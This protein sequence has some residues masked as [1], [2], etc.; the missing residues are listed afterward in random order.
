MHMKAKEGLM[1]LLLRVMFSSLMELRGNVSPE[2][3]YLPGRCRLP[4][5]SILQED[6]KELTPSRF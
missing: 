4:G 3:S 6:K 5:L 1:V 2:T